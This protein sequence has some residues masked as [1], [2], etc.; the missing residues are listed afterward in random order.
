MTEAR[1]TRIFVSCDNSPLG[2]EALHAAAA[3]ARRMDAELT[4][5]YV[6]DANL[7]RMASLPFAR[8]VTL[9]GATPRPLDEN[10]LKL[11]LQRRANALRIALSE[12]ARSLSVRWSFQVV[13]GTLLDSLLKEMSEPGL[14]VLGHAGQYVV[15]SGGP[16]RRGEAQLAEARRPLLVLYDGSAPARR[17]LAVAADMARLHHAPLMI[18]LD[19][20]REH[21]TAAL[22][23]RVEAELRDREVAFRFMAIPTR[24]ADAVKQ[25][26]RLHHAAAL[27]W[28][29][30]PGETTRKA[31]AILVDELTCPVLL[32]T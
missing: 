2:V 19:H 4:G 14:A 16:A 22:R 25:A 30:V 20:Q 27:F 8:E 17:A 24:D 23:D 31:L 9:S 26:A 18:A 29:G 3:L 28:P 1:L 10:E 15:T 13:R 6:E 32:V 5:V 7:L 21:D 11:A 12:E